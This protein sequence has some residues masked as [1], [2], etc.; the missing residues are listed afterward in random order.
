MLKADLAFWP[1]GSWRIVF[2]LFHWPRAMWWSADRNNKGI[3]KSGAVAFL[4]RFWPVLGP[5]GLRVRVRAR[6]RGWVGST[7][8]PRSHQKVLLS[9]QTRIA[10]PPKDRH[11][12]I[13]RQ[14][15]C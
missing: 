8:V 6:V 2:A 3:L 13:A 12:Q 7:P 15:R 10:Y 9:S 14:A 11:D 5:V 1:R 4:A